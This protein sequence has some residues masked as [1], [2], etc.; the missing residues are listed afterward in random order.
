ME[1]AGV[2]IYV[3]DWPAAVTW[4]SEVLGLTIGP[5]EPDDQFCM[6]MAGAGFIGIA[7]DHPEY[8]EGSQENRVAPSIRVDDLDETLRSLRDRGVAVDERADGEGEGYR[9]T[10][11]WDPEGNRLNIFSS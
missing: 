10:R 7:S 9:L 4:Y 8:A 5:Y 3:R 6:M 1:L 2:T 11:V